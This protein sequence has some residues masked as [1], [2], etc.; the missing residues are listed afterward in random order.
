[1]TKQ[2]EYYYDIVQGTDEWLRIKHGVVSASVFK[3]IITAKT[4][5][6]SMAEKTTTFF[7]QILSERVDETIYPSFVNYAMERGLEDE[8]YAVQQYAEEYNQE[9][10]YCGFVINRQLGFPLGFSPD[11]LIGEDGFIEIKSKQPNLQIKTILDHVCGRSKDLIPSEHMMQCQAGLF[12]TQREWCD[13]ISFCNGFPMATIRV[14]PIDRFQEAIANAAIEVEEVLQQNQRDY[15][16]AVKNNPQLTITPRR[17][18]DTE[19]VI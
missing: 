2:I 3:N 8:P 6:L 12:V 19:I 16:C 1:M 15:E 17:I 5:K 9:Y 7:D 13:F 4:L 11:A 18:V 10:K 14:H